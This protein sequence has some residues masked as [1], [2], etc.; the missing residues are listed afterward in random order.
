MTIKKLMENMETLENMKNAMGINA[1]GINVSRMNDGEN[2]IPYIYLIASDE[3]EKNNDRIKKIDELVKEYPADK[4]CTAKEKNAKQA[5]KL[6]KSEL[7]TR[8]GELT[9]LLANFADENGNIIAPTITPLSATWAFSKGT[10]VYANA[11]AVA[12]QSMMLELVGKIH[13]NI[14]D[15]SDNMLEFVENPEKRCGEIYKDLKGQLCQLFSLLNGKDVTANQKDVCDIISNAIHTKNG[16]KA[17]S[18]ASDRK[19]S[20]AKEGTLL[21]ICCGVLATKLIDREMPKPEKAKK[22]EK[23]ENAKDTEKQNNAEQAQAQAEQK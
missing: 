11:L 21:R 12:N 1:N 22:A 10:K 2:I 9:E 13:K 3:Q 23:Q 19:V 16:V 15:H 5:L 4:E 17:D 7:E 14:K 20:I 6:E 18:T 8:N